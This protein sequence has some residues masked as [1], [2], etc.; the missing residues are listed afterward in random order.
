MQAALL[1]TINDFS[2]HNIFLLWTI[3][4][5]LVYRICHM[6][7]SSVLSK[8]S[9]KELYMGYYC[10]SS[11]TH[12]FRKDKQNFNNK[13]EIWQPRGVIR[14]THLERN[15]TKMQCH[16]QL[17]VRSIVIY[18]RCATGPIYHCSPIQMSCTQIRVSLK[19]PSIFCCAK[20]K[21]NGRSTSMPY[22]I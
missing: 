17:V 12:I 4:G 5:K 13:M 10:F 6:D 19:T 3:Q 22:V 1:Q 15:R 9:K 7:N 16:V 21:K 18:F 20:I 2:I 14:I 11:I 8:V